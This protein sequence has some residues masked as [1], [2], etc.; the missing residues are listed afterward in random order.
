MIRGTL[1]Q[2]KNGPNKLSVGDVV[3]ISIET[4]KIGYVLLKYPSDIARRLI[5]TGKILFHSTVEGASTESIGFVFEDSDKKQK[6]ND[7]NDDEDSFDFSS[8]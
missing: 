3:L 4:D 6:S 7:N 1:Q 2:Q 5:K 8:I